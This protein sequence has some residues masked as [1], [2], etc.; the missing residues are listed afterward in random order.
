MSDCVLTANSASQSGG[1]LL[2]DGT[3]TLSDCVLTANSASLLGGG[4]LNS[5]TATL[6]D[7]VL[8]ANSAS[9]SG[10][11]IYNIGTAT[12]SDCVLAANSASQSGGGIYNIGTATL[13]DCVLTANSASQSGGGVL[14]DGTATLSGCVLTANSAQDG[15]GVYNRAAVAVT[16]SA[17]KF[18]SAASMCNNTDNGALDFL[19][20]SCDL[21]DA[22]PD[23]C[24]LVDDEEFDASEMCCAC[25]GGSGSYGG[26]I[27]NS[28]TS[29]FLDCQLIANS[30]RVGQALF[31]AEFAFS[32][33]SNCSFR[34]RVANYNDC[35]S[36]DDGAVNPY[37]DGCDAYAFNRWWCGNY[38]DSDFSSNDMCC[39]CGGGVGYDVDGCVVYSGLFSELEFYYSKTFPN[40]TVCPA[41]SAT[42]LVYNS[43][44]PLPLVVPSDAGN[45]IS[46][47]HDAIRDYCAFDCSAGVGG[48]GIECR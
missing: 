1:G 6:S 35:V 3:A 16:G 20:H 8:T 31:A 9:E 5:A 34:G 29:T 32:S 10:G 28:G 21:Y 23:L 41:S 43:I 26:G 11:G 14:N 44:T 38:D 17:L 19:G 7:C 40:G 46:C 22:Y 42:V 15:G 25:G 2:N 45:I 48:A 30:A 36:S 24:G 37:G 12:L 47:Q 4:L 39:A 18:N 33:F 13:S 27:Y